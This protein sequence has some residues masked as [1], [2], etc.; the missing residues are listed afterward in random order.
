[1]SRRLSQL[2]ISLN[3]ATYVAGQTV[4]GEV[5]L[6][7]SPQAALK[8]SGAQVRLHGEARTSWVNKTSDNIYDSSEP[9]LNLVSSLESFMESLGGDGELVPQGLHVIPFQ[10]VL[11][12][13]LPSSFEGKH[14]PMVV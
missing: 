14:Y 10:F 1:M 6:E 9:L 7:V 3:S 12:A 5:R 11:P 13:N 8:L 2:D 4:H